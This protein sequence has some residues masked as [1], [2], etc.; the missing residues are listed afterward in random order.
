MARILVMED[1][2][3]LRRI[4]VNTLTSDGHTVIERETGFAAYDNAMLDSIDLMITDLVMPRVDGLDAIRTALSSHGDLKIIAMSGG[5]PNL[6]HDYLGVAKTFG[7]ASVLHKPFEPQ[8]L[9][10]AVNGA[11]AV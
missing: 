8:S 7:A 9:L 6:E 5:S 2:D 3:P 4:V 11:L 1:S 10:D